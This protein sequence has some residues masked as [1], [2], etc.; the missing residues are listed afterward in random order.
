M[1][2]LTETRTRG[3]AAGR[4]RAQLIQLPP[5]TFSVYATTSS[6]SADAGDTAAPTMTSSGRPMRP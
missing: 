4:K 1:R 5:A 2:R 3:K 6:A